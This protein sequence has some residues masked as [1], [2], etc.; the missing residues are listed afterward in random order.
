MTEVAPSLDPLALSA[1]LAATYRRYVRST[2]APRDS[3]FREALRDGLEHR[4]DISRGPFLQAAAPYQPGASVSELVEE[5]TLARAFLRM[6]PAAFP[7]ERPLYLHQEQA[8]R[9]ITGGRNLIVATGTG[10]GKTECFLLPI[11][12]HLH[13]EAEAGTVGQAGVRALLLYPMN[14]LANDQ[15]R[16][17]RELLAPFPDITFGRYV[18]DTAEQY[19]QALGTYRSR[20]GKAPPSNE[21]ISREEMQK[22]PPHVLLTNYAMLEYLL[23]RPK[24]SSFF[25]GDTAPH[26]RF[27]VLDEVHVYDGAKGAELG[28]LLRRVR[29]RVHRSGRGRIRCIA[30]SATL[31]KDRSDLP[32]LAAFATALFDEE[33]TWEPDSHQDVIE[34]TRLPLASAKAEWLLAEDRVEEIR[35]RFRE[36]ASAAELAGLLSGQ[37][38][39]MEPPPDGE[40]PAAYLARILARET[41][42]VKLQRRLEDGS[43][44]LAE[45]GPAVFRGPDA[46]RRLVALVDLCVAARASDHDAPLLPARYHF[47]LRALEGGFV[48]LAPRHPDGEPRLLL[49]RHE[50][51]PACEQAGA[52]SMMF[53]FGVCRR[54]GAGYL[55]GVPATGEDGVTRLA[56]ALLFE[57]RLTYLLVDTPPLEDEDEDEDESAVISDEE[58]A[59]SLDRTVVCTSC[60]AYAEAQTPG[61]G[62]GSAS[63][64][65]ATA[66]RPAK[67]GD[68]VRRCPACSGRSNTAIVSR[69]L[70]GADAPVAVIATSLYQGLPPSHDARQRAKVGAGRKLLSFS[71]SRQDA[72]FFAPYLD[73]TYSRAVERRLIWDV[74]QSRRADQPRLGDLEVPIRRA[75]EEALVLDEDD[76]AAANSDRVRTWLMREVL[77]V[78]R[79]QS[80]EGTGLA[81][82]TVALPRNL[83]APARLLDLG[84]SAEECFDLA[85]LLL[86]TVRAS[87]AVHLP[88]GVDIND[89]IF[90][91]RNAITT[92]R[93]EGSERGVLAWLPGRGLEPAPRLPSAPLPS[94]RTHRRPP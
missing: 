9:N 47:L 64:M 6:D 1:E 31:G 13:R 34:P 5:G 59:T 17:L 89:P 58:S 76:G 57:D 83:E 28:M 71:D 81:E 66:A 26:W 62:C 18:G 2:F 44:D 33:F 49:A 51:C 11:I 27:I 93:G 72:A 41:H 73:R 87:A 54:C 36:G 78:D 4:F 80:L 25:D 75:A 46:S 12:D 48:C 7:V 77:G 19:K 21:L 24:D 69:F 40:D 52:S 3:R 60:R 56:T 8:I 86:D 50:T 55:V 82:I 94:S 43:V 84:F 61:C 16:R 65:A 63:V 79:R 74:L 85:R 30:T 53:E 68:V 91:P 39:A 92:I 20:F 10:S 45:V 70:T 67:T 88:P 90:A 15:I 23:L 14:T 22:R 29:D 32:R 42:V 37:L 35:D 38:P